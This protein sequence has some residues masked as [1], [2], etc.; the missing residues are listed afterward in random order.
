MIADITA[1]TRARF[2]IKVDMSEDCWI[3]TASRNARGY[4]SFGIE[5][6]T[7]LAHRVS[8]EMH[9][10]ALEPGEH[11]D[12]LCGVTSCVN[13]AHLDACSPEENLRRQIAAGRHRSILAERNAAKRA[14]PRGHAY[15][16]VRRDGYRRCSQ[17][18]RDEE[19][20]RKLRTK[21]VA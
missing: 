15:D 1:A 3:W 11:V 14:C 19:R 9:H 6:R 12:H 4:G 13:P 17:C 10:R 20:A 16:T 21:A 2:W 5:G 8:F 7:F 18:H